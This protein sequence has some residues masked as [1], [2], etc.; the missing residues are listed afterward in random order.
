MNTL[1]GIK[2]YRMKRIYLY[3]VFILLL[4]LQLPFLQSDPDKM[5]D[6]DKRGA[7]TDEGLY[8]SQ[9]RNY[10]NGHGFDIDENSTL[11]RGPVFGLIQ[12]PF[13]SVFGSKLIVSRLVVLLFTIITLLILST[14]R[15]LRL[16]VFILSIVSFFQFYVFHYSHF[17]MAEML[18]V[19]FILLAMFFF[20]KYY[21]NENKHYKWLFLSSLMIFLSYS[22]KIQFA[23]TI[24]I[25]PISLS[26]LCFSNYFKTKTFNK[27]DLKAI[28]LSLIFALALVLIYYIAWYLPNS[29]FYNYVMSRETAERY[30]DVLI[31]Y[32]G[33]I[34]FSILN[35]FWV[36]SLKILMIFFVISL[37]VIIGFRK[38]ANIKIFDNPLMIFVCIWFIIE[39][40]KIP[41]QYLPTR[42]LLSIFVAIGAFTSFVLSD[43]QKSQKK[44]YFI[45]LVI[46]IGLFNLVF[47][48]KS[49][50]RRTYDLK[51]ANEY[52]LNYD[53][54]K[55]TIIG[56]WA[57]SFSWGTKARTLPVWN[58]FLN[59]KNPI[60]ETNASIVVSESDE[61]CSDETYLSQNIILENHSD[62]AK[63]FKAGKY[64]LIF[65]W[66]KEE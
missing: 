19:D 57:A 24:V 51:S 31:Q 52:L 8:S 16:F 62:S 4:F 36:S 56:P 1:I 49:Y 44:P 11:I 48:I 43:L 5:V 29:E 17:G 40:H 9:V 66:I 63:Q 55:K 61:S 64:D 13:L 54:K 7:W 27:H 3:I 59:Y 12:Y 46:L 28:F 37:I 20:H 26:V 35:Y 53:L 45:I 60:S 39:I 18:C 42:Y 6:I 41:M 32:P 22:T 58:D 14:A 21:S 2:D 47:V 25:I 50:N 65:Y 30:S 23:Y 33:I 15:D 38:K 34:K 10:I